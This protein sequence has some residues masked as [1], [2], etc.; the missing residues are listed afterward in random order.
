LPV[1]AP[2]VL[3]M[4]FLAAF[5]PVPGQQ[6][7][8]RVDRRMITPNRLTPELYADRLAL[9]ITL[10]NLPGAK[11]SNSYWQAEYKI[12]F[13]PERD[14]EEITKQLAK[15][16]KTKDLKPEY[17]PSKVLLAEGAVSKRGVASLP[18]RT[19]ARRD[20]EFKRKITPERQTSFSSI[21]SFYTVKIYDAE[22]KKTIYQSDLFIVPPFD[23]DSPDRTSMLPRTDL[24]LSFFVASDG[25]LYN[26][27]RKRS[28]ESSEWKPY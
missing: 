3:L 27:N 17:F 18:E 2:V 6:P 10:V 4:L 26:S 24:Y 14:F 20:I 16:G 19:F 5:A 23:T 9:K 22:L 15:E 13:V 25:S 21:L 8:A 1:I 11:V 12:F 7:K 28:S